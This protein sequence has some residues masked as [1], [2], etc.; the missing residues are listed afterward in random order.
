MGLISQT[1]I[2]GMLGTLPLLFDHL[3]WK[4]PLETDGT[5]THQKVATF[6]I[7]MIKDRYFGK[8]LEIPSAS[9]KYRIPYP[10]LSH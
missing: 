10:S 6:P 2:K 9:D 8:W 4:K 5:L 1:W 3:G 7:G